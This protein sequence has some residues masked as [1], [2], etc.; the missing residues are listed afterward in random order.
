MT[1]NHYKDC[2]FDTTPM[3]PTEGL[4]RAHDQNWDKCLWAAAKFWKEEHKHLR[5]MSDLQQAELK[6]LQQDLYAQGDE[7][8]WAIR[9]LQFYAEDKNWVVPA[10]S[11][12]IALT[13]S[14]QGR[15]AREFL[16]KIRE[17]WQLGPDDPLEPEEPPGPMP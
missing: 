14:D 3:G 5:E 13:R 9:V 6:K 15:R 17:R 12:A 11:M 8:T 1:W 2:D 4:C 7:V 16:A 10:D